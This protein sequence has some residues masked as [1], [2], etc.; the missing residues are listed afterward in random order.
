LYP[1]PVTTIQ[2]QV[3]ALKA[4]VE[5]EEFIPMTLQR[6]CFGTSQLMTGKQ[7]TTIPHSNHQ[8]GHDDLGLLL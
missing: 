6:L 1:L 5:N 2:I 7:A 8:D 4:Q 3:E